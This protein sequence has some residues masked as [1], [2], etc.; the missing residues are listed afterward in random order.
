M[1]VEGS[2]IGSDKT[3]A[4]AMHAQLSDQNVLAGSGPRNR[5]AVRIDLNQL[6]TVDQALQVL[7]EFLTSGTM[8]SQFAQQLP[9][10]GGVFGL[11]FDLLQNGGIGE[12]VQ[13]RGLFAAQI[14]I[15]D[16]PGPVPR[17]LF[18]AP[19]TCLPK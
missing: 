7:G 5:V 19:S 16:H 14:I 6:A 3:V 10:A 17:R 9:E 2:G 8:Q 1:W 15:R 11:A 13:D 4:I 18:S 12:F